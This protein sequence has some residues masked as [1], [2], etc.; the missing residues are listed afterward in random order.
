MAT[1]SRYT[2][3]LA[4]EGDL[5]ALAAFEVEIARI[6]FADDAIVDPATHRHRLERAMSRDG[7]GML[8]AEEEGRVAG[9]LWVSINRNFTTGARY[10]Q[11]RSLAVAPED[12]DGDLAQLLFERGIDHAREQG[13]GEVIGH[14]HVDNAPMRLV[15]RAFGF[16]PRH[17]T[18]RRVLR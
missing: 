8:V 16:E 13:A 14:V 5:D 9:W 17:L 12:R 7:S 11:F 1:L 18:M 2:I 4:E 15:Y 3:R 6:S 10:A